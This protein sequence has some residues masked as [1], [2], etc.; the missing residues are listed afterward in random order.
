MFVMESLKKKKCKK[1]VAKDEQTVNNTNF[2]GLT[3][4]IILKHLFLTS[5]PSHANLMIGYFFIYRISS[6]SY[7]RTASCFSFKW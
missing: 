3:R 7:R 1:T 5:F 6:G 2:H 4:W